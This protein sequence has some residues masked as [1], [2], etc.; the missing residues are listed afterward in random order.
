MFG[1]DRPPSGQFDPEVLVPR[2][3]ADRTD[4]SIRAR[5][6][7]VVNSVVVH[8]S[9]GKPA[10]P[11]GTFERCLAGRRSCSLLSVAQ[12]CGVILFYQS[13]ALSLH[14]IMILPFAAL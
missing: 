2:H 10:W 14:A 7:F 3:D 11:V 13:V 8:R 12:C 1:R 9:V 6:E 5:D 4:D